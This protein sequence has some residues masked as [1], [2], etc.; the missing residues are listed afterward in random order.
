[1]QAQAT[2]LFQFFGQPNRRAEQV[3]VNAAP[4][5][6]AWQMVMGVNVGDIV[7]VADWQ[8]GGSGNV[9]T[10]RVTEIKREIRFG[11]KN[12]GDVTA[13]IELIC[14]AEPTSWWS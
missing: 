13:Q 6:A 11:G 10:F 14:D 5:P 12:D 8:I 1:M 3:K 9:N 2:W 4:Y 7:T